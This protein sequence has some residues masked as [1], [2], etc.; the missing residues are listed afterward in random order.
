MNTWIGV[1]LGGTNLRAALADD[2]GRIL[3]TVKTETEAD[4]GAA[5]VLN[6]VADAIRML[7][8]WE[9][10]KGIGMGIPG[11][12]LK[13]GET[14]VLTSNLVGFDG[15]PVRSHLSSLTG[16]PAV[17]ENDG[18]AACLAEALLGAGQGMETVVYV[19]LSTGIGGG[20]CVNGRLLHGAHGCSGE[21][22]CIS[23]DPNRVSNG[24]LPPGAIESEASGTALVRKAGAALG[25]AF[26]HAGEVYD[27]AASGHPGA[28]ELVNRSIQD[29]A[30]TLSN[31][32]SVLDPDIFVL[33]G[34]CL[35]S[36]D[37]LLPRLASRFRE[38]AHPAF[39]DIPIRKGLLDEPGLIGAALCAKSALS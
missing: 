1:D 6:R 36:A 8:G 13:D 3:H 26:S 11:G 28:E 14:A 10:A 38:F 5:C 22:G 34:G 29:L 12:V 33:G 32:A 16:K 30:V 9:E 4:K 18:N 21:F 31:I 35:K 24:D 15:F 20:I 37:I 17:L 27:L 25:I 39:R 7:P 19:T 23:C 2:R